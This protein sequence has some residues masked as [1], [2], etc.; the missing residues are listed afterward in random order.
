MNT[1]EKIALT[2]DLYEMD[3]SYSATLKVL[4]LIVAAKDCPLN[5]DD[6]LGNDIDLPSYFN[7]KY[8]ECDLT[9][10]GFNLRGMF[11]SSIDLSH[12]IEECE[13]NFKCLISQKSKTRP[14]CMMKRFSK[15]AFA[16]VY[17]NGTYIL[18]AEN[19]EKFCF[20]FIHLRRFLTNFYGCDI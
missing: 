15:E 12:E 7:D 17:D 11:Q 13:D 9:K 20:Y 10:N 2:D 4:G 3:Q 1:E 16:V 18:H 19:R 6:F 8:L 14:G 5:E